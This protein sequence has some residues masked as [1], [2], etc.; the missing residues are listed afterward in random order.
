MIRP[1]HKTLTDD[2]SLE[3]LIWA[4]AWAREGLQGLLGVMDKHPL[5][6]VLQDLV[7]EVRERPGRG[8][9]LLANVHFE[10]GIRAAWK[11]LQEVGEKV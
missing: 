6:R 10:L 8:A 4:D 5:P 3:A 7:N 9:V 11:R 2:V 1:E